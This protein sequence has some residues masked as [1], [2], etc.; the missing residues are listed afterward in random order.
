MANHQMRLYSKKGMEIK[1]YLEPFKAISNSCRL[2]IIGPFFDLSSPLQDPVIFVDGGAQF[3]SGTMGL[4]VGDGDST[5]IS[6][7]QKLNAEK[8]FSDLSFVLENISDEFTKIDLLG[9]LGH[10]NDHQLMN[11]AEVHRFLKVKTIKQAFVRF[12]NKIVVVACGSWKVNI[13]GIFSL[14]SFEPNKISLSGPCD[15]PIHAEDNFKP[16]SSQGLSNVGHGEISLTVTSPLFIFSDSLLLL[17][18]I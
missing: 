12:D 17:S 16:L 2:Q 4:S 13:H 11:W 3:R 14:F 18:E 10:R 9:F 15:Y 1:K 7:D 6:M 8:D 5:T